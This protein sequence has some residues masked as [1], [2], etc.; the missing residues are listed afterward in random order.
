M[1]SNNNFWYFYQ[2]LFSFSKLKTLP[3]LMSTSIVN[4]SSMRKLV[5]REYLPFYHF[6]LFKWYP[7]RIVWPKVK[8]DNLLT[9]SLQA[10]ACLT[11][12]SGVMAQ[13]PTMPTVICPSPDCL[14]HGGINGAA[15]GGENDLRRWWGSVEYITSRKRTVWLGS[16][17]G[18]YERFPIK[19]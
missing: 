12:L 1:Y 2:S 5:F 10:T 11:W 7:S 19:K 9:L 17:L 15:Q 16:L 13:T 14:E 8:S 3:S 6:R 4:Y 18:L